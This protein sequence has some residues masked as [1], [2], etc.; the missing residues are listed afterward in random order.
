MKGRALLS[1]GLLLAAQGVLAE[2]GIKASAELGLI[3]ADGNTETQSL[4]AKGGVEHTAGK[5]RNSASLEA[6]NVKGTVDGDSVR[7]GEK[8]VGAGKSVYQ[9]GEHS[10]GF[11]TA[12]GEHDPFSGFAY[13]VVL[14]AGYGYRV[15]NTAKATLDLEVG[16]GYRQ[17]RLRSEDDA[18]GDAI[19]RLALKGSWA[20]TETS[21]LTQDLVTEGAD[22]WITKSVTALTTKVSTAL[23]LKVALGI[24][25]NSDSPEG[26]ESTDTELAT[27]LVYSF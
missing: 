14:S 17:T 3:I 27:T 15:Y 25:N 20:I 4:N 23:S 2:D 13:Q 22:Y 19:A 18:E 10:Y 7:L 6:L 12:S 1:V 21:T 24:K 5:Y 8:Y 16:P 26:T 11:V 9:F